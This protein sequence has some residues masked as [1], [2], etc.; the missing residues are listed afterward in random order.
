MTHI[1]AYLKM[2]HITAYYVLGLKENC[3]IELSKVVGFFVCGGTV[4]VMSL[5]K[6]YHCT[7]IHDRCEDLPLQSPAYT[8]VVKDLPLQ[9]PA[10]TIVVKVLP[11]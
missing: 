9:S 4:F 11:L 1:T 7:S 10:Y 3:V 8:I 6:D 2:I 5:V